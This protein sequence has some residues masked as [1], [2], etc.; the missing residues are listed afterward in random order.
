MAH[1]ALQNQRALDL[2]TSDK[3]GNCL[4]LN[5]ECCYYINESNVVETNI[6]ALTKIC[7]SL[8]GQPHPVIKPSQWWLSPLTTWLLPILNPIILF[9]LLE[10]IT[11]CVLCFIQER[12]CEVSRVTVN[13]PLLDPYTCLSTYKGPYDDAP[14]PAG[15]S[16]I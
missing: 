5:E 8:G 14:L 13:Q 12:I 11:P 7:D 10:L 6:S 3:G 16:Q 15:G 2:L 1:V 4:F 9:C